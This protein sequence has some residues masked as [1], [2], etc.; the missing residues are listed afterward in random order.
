M[1]FYQ[2]FLLSPIQCTVY[3]NCKR[4]REFEEYKSV[5]KAVEETVNSKD[6]NSK[7]FCLDVAPELGHQPDVLGNLPPSVCPFLF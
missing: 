1:V 2:V 4:L 6:E 5:G 7:D 3:R